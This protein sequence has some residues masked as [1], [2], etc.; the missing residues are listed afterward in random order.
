MIDIACK[1]ASQAGVLDTIKFQEGA[2]QDISY[3][4]G[5]HLVTNPPYGK[6]LLEDDLEGL[7]DDLESVFTKNNLLG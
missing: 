6:R 7:Y 4:S 2:L 5:A 3:E 1:N